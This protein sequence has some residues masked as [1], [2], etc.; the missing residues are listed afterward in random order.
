[1]TNLRLTEAKRLLLTSDTCVQEVASAV[2][3]TN[4]SQFYKVFQRYSSMS[5]ADY[6]RYYR[7]SGGAKVV[8]GRTAASRPG[9]PGA[10]AGTAARDGRVAIAV[11][12]RC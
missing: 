7:S 8:L 10:S 9:V 1:V 4:L 3:Y 11:A 6:R 5:P 2:G 12:R